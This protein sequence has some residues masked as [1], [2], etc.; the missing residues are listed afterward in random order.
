V[1]SVSLFR[2][3]TNNGAC[4][5]EFRGMGTCRLANKYSSAA[6]CSGDFSTGT[7]TVVVGVGVGVGVGAFGSCCG[8]GTN[9]C[10]GLD[11]DVTGGGSTVIILLLGSQKE[12]QIYAR[13]LTGKL[14]IRMINGDIALAKMKEFGR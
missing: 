4:P 7:D 14:R 13:I 5:F 12:L 3:L 2:I 6:T 8:A 10:M 1:V 11:G 9:A